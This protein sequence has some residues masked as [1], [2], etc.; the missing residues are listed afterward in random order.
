MA[1]A[2]GLEVFDP[3]MEK[4]ETVWK[5]ARCRAL[6]KLPPVVIKH[7]VLFGLHRSRYVIEEG[8]IAG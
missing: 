4:K 5:D 1:Q 3:S 8:K 6:S 2:L 7:F